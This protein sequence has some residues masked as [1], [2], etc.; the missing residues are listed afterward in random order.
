MISMT[1]SIEAFSVTVVTFDVICRETGSSSTLALP[2][3]IARTMSRSDT[4]PRTLDRGVRH[5]G[6]ADALGGQQRRDFLHRAMGLGRE[7]IPALFPENARNGHSGLP[8]SAAFLT[9]P[10]T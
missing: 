1:W 4:M 9:R 3:P 7:D 10:P 8:R 2:R 5:D 6:G